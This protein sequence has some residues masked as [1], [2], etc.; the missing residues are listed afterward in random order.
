MRTTK[1]S[2]QGLT[3]ERETVKHSV[4]EYVNKQ[5][6][7]NGIESF[8]ALLKRGYHGMYYKSI[9][10]DTWRGGALEILLRAPALD[11]N[12]RHSAFDCLNPND[13]ER[14]TKEVAPQDGPMVLEP[15]LRGIGA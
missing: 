11:R 2:Y 13:F 12:G 3:Y 6:H 7:T 1:K 14:S 8:W 10:R 5:A 4:G 9:W 15:T